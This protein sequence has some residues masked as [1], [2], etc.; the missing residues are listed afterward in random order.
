[1]L[2]KFKPKW[3]IHER[4]NM[5]KLGT[6]KKVGES[7]NIYRYDNGW[8]VE[9]TGRDKESDWI[10]SKIVCNSEQEVVALFTQYNTIEIDR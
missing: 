9:I 3:P 8:M 2:R 1:M 6:M 4:K 10:T 7:F 5:S